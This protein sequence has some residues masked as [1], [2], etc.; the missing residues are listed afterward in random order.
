MRLLHRMRCY[1]RFTKESED[2]SRLAH[3]T[4]S[5]SLP[6]LQVSAISGLT[7]RAFEDRAS[8]VDPIHIPSIQLSARSRNNVPKCIHRIH[9]FTCSGFSGADVKLN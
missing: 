5:I 3:Q 9:Q 2:N 8:G 6:N 4:Q 7:V 1:G